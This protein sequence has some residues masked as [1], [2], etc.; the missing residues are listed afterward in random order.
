M[1]KPDLLEKKLSQISKAKEVTPDITNISEEEV[2]KEISETLDFR[3]LRPGLLYNNF[4]EVFPSIPPA[5]IYA[6]KEQLIGLPVIIL[7]SRVDLENAYFD[8]NGNYRYEDRTTVI[9]NITYVTAIDKRG[10][11]SVISPIFYDEPIKE[12][13]ISP[14]LKGF[15]LEE[16]YWLSR[17]RTHLKSEIAILKAR[18]E[19]LNRFLVL[20][21]MNKNSNLTNLEGLYLKR[22]ITQKIKE[23]PDEISKLLLTLLMEGK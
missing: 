9:G 14:N 10:R 21:D 20:G 17:N 4:T 12:A 1:S 6:E 8:D 5:E 3:F 7:K 16:I 23:N 15:R 22:I 11:I 18:I 13:K 19:Y 2:L